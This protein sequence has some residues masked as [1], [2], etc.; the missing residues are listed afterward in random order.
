MLRIH[1]VLFHLGICGA[2]EPCMPLQLAHAV[3]L[4]AEAQG[5]PAVPES[6]FAPTSTQMAAVSKKM[7]AF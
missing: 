7:A 6:Y 2:H 1:G 3:R 5:C 4:A